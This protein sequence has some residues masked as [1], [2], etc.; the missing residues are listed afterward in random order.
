MNVL[1]FHCFLIIIYRDIFLCTTVFQREDSLTVFRL[2]ESRTAVL[3]VW[4]E[5]PGLNSCVQAPG[6]GFWGSRYS[7][8]KYVCFA[9]F[10]EP[11]WL[12]RDV[13]KCCVCVMF[14]GYESHCWPEKL[15]TVYIQGLRGIF[16]DHWSLGTC[17]F[18]RKL[19]S[20]H[21]VVEQLLS[22]QSMEVS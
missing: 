15:L 6:R 2:W 16:P 9:Y 8:E 4:G 12:I 5:C 1:K 11:L 18:L 7:D 21:F 20:Q 13:R 14:G 22:L 17:L 10:S 3:C 19:F